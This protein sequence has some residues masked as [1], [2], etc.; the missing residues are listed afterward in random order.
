MR[1]LE[2]LAGVVHGFLSFGHALGVVFH[3]KRRSWKNATIHLLGLCYDIRAIRKHYQASRSR[4]DLPPP[5]H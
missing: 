1:Q 2:Y 3:I 4:H 5:R